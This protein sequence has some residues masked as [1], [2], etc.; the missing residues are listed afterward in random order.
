[1]KAYAAKLAEMGYKVSYIDS[2]RLLKRGDL[3]NILAE[4]GIEHLHVADFSDEWLEQDLQAKKLTFY[5]SPLFICSKDEIRDFFKGKK[6]FSMASFYAFQ[7]RRLDILMDG[8]EPVG[9]KFSFDVENRK[10]LPKGLVPP[11]HYTPKRNAFV[12]EAIAYIKKEFPDAIGEADPFLYSTTHEEAEKALFDFI[13]HRLFHFG[14]YEDA[15]SIKESVLYHSVISPLL[16]I[17]LLTPKQVVEAVLVSWK[18]FHIPLNSLEG[19]IRQI[20]GWREFIR[21]CYLLKGRSMRISNRLGHK[22]PLPKGFWDGTTGIPPIDNTIKKILQ[23]GY[24]HHIERLMILGNFLLLN[25]CDPDAVYE[26]FMGYFVDSY[27]WVMVPNVYAMSQYA[28]YGSITTKPYIS[29]ANYIHKM[30]DY[31]KGDWSEIW[32]GLFWRFISK[33]RSLFE[34]NPRTMVL[35]SLLN[36]NA[37]TIDPKIQ[38]ANEWLLQSHK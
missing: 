35:L 15:I 33:Y 27:D 25:E 20:I 8:H 36:K 14:D 5:P 4:E 24:C 10:K 17:G 28:D 6:K 22:A 23:T 21:A 32:D 7:R 30:S 18:K 2:G 1:M 11:L 12:S 31:K 37:S 16:N 38:R 29:G 34:A 26:W 13:E 19:F 9:G 3:F